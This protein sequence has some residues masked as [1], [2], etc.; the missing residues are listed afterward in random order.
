MN[1]E[2]CGPEAAPERLD[3]T[4][5]DRLRQLDPDGKHGV[6]NRVLSTYEN[7]LQRQM[8]LAS[9]AGQQG[10]TTF[11]LAAPN[12]FFALPEQVKAQIDKRNSRHFRGWERVGAE[13]TD[14]RVD[15]RE[16]LDLSTENEPYPSDAMP[17]YLRLE[18]GRA[19]V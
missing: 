17:A 12:D 7:S 3:A 19:H 13:L 11:R 2:S 18:I 4:A 10:D 9:Q 5:L 1:A 8:E 15:Y 6:V 14:N 16:Q